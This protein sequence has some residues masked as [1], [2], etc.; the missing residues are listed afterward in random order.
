MPPGRKYLLVL[1]GAPHSLISGRESPDV[2]SSR[3]S[4]DAGG[5]ALSSRAA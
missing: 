1:A 4:A 2:A 5:G 3:G